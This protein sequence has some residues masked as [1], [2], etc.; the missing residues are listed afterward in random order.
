MISVSGKST[1]KRSPESVSVCT[2]TTCA[3]KVIASAFVTF[4]LTLV[5]TLALARHSYPLASAHW[6]RHQHADK[7]SH[8]RGRDGNQQIAAGLAHD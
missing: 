1:V 4:A 3:G 7:A 5:L 6:R 8:D 2:L